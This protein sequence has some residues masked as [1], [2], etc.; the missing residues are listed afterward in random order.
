MRNNLTAA[1][2]GRGI[3]QIPLGPPTVVVSPA[4]ATGYSGAS[5]T[6]TAS[7]IGTPT[8]NY[9]WQYDGNN[10]SGANGATFTISNAQPTNAGLYRVIVS[11]AEGSATSSVSP[12]TIITSPPYRTQTLAAGPVAYWRL[13]ETSGPT[14]VDSIGGFNGTDLGSL[15]FGVTGPIAPAF[16][17]FESGNT[18]YQFDGTTTGISVPALNLNTNT[19]TI[20]AWVNGTG[21]QATRAG[22]FFWRD[23]VGNGWGLRFGSA[24][25]LGYTLNGSIYDSPLTVPTNQW[26]FVT[27]VFTPTNGI[28]YMATNSTL[29][30]WTNHV[31]TPTIAFNTAA[32][33]GQDTG[34]S[35]TRLVNGG[36]DEV[37]LFNQSLTGSQINNLLS[38][39]L[40]SLPAVT[41]TAP[42]D[43]STLSATPSIL[44]TASVTTNGHAIGAVKFYD[45]AALLGQ[46]TTPPYQFTWTG[47]ANGIH[48]LLAQVTYDG[49]STISSSPANITVTNA[50]S[51]NTT[52]TNIVATV[53]GTNFTL[54]WPA[55][56]TGWRLL[57]QTN[58]LANGVSRNTNDWIAITGSASTNQITIPIIRTNKA[59]FFRL[60]YP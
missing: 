12:L 31:A 24:N 53:S 30:S 6:F 55:D 42:A 51:V 13:N 32:A 43:G 48:T 38:A 56:H 20:T 36:I 29:V 16:P 23:G 35:T 26:T 59:G 4:T 18:A 45:S 49:S 50:S 25:N 11:N 27:L 21:T 3:W 28:I 8:L 54:S 9:Q 34:F 60:I 52:P 37:A 57:S 17:G 15:S 39:S 46:S 33:I 14:A 5:F 44:L 47:A 22:I 7:A 2:G 1:T 41:L 58:N 19:I 10:L 40:T